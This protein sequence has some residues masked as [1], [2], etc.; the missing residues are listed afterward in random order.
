MRIA[1]KPNPKAEPYDSGPCAFV[2]YDPNRYDPCHDPQC[3]CH[4]S[5]N[6]VRGMGAT[7]AEAIADFWEQWEEA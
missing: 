7:E 4:R 5:R 1:D 3:S 6:N 2:A